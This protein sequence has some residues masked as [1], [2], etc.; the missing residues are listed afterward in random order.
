MVQSNLGNSKSSELEILFRIIRNWNY[1][2]VDIKEIYTPPPTKKNKNT[3]IIFSIK[4]TSLAY[5]LYTFPLSAQNVWYRQLLKYLNLECPKF[6]LNKQVFRKS[7]IRIFN[8][9]LFMY[10]CCS[11][12]SLTHLCRMYF[13]IVINW[14]SPFP[15]LGLLG[16]IF[17]F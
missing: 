11:Y 8:V 6:I 3:F 9:L 1:R 4:H 16:D 10:Y 12:D 7:T 2:E 17:H 15:I 5:V 14:T 13:P